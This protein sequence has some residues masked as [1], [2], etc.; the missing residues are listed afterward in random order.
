MCDQPLQ[1]FAVSIH[2]PARGATVLGLHTATYTMFQSTHPHG[3]RL[4]KRMQAVSQSVFQSTHPHGVRLQ[5]MSVLVFGLSFNPRTRTGCD[6][7]ISTIICIL[8]NVSIHAPARGA[9]EDTLS[10]IS[11]HDVSIHA[12][13]RGATPVFFHLVGNIVCFNPRTRTGCDS[14]KNILDRQMTVSIHAPARGATSSRL[15]DTAELAFQSTH[16]HGVRQ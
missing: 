3:V 12:P 6:L 15:H 2:A 1:V 16:P 11:T 5:K 7:I 13:A 8:L 10:H 14:D 9:T 4:T